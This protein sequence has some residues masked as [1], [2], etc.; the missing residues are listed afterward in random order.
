MGLSRSLKRVKKS[1]KK[2]RERTT[3]IEA[4]WPLNEKMMKLH[5]W[6]LRFYIHAWNLSEI[7]SIGSERWKR[8]V[9]CAHGKR[10]ESER[11][12]EY[13]REIEKESCGAEQKGPSEGGW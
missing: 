4:T 11:R 5:N 10:K 1:G 3:P 6:H 7:G 9:R 2:Q 12:V 8:L 13:L